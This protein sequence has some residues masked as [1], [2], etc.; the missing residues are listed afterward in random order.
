MRF[1]TGS[2]I[3]FFSALCFWGRAQ[4]PD[5]KLSKQEKDS[6][7]TKI[8]HLLEHRYV[9]PEKGKALNAMLLQKNENQ[10]FDSISDPTIFRE[11]IHNAIRDK[12]DDKHMRLFYF[13][14][15]ED[16]SEDTET[17]D[18]KQQYE[19]RKAMN[20]GIPELKVLDNNIG[21]LKVTKFT[22]PELFGPA[23]SASS[24]FLKNVEGLILDFRSRGGGNSDAVVLMLSYFLPAET[25]VFYWLD[26]NGN[27]L[28]RNWTFPYVAG[29]RFKDIPIVVL[30]SSKTFSGSEAFSYVMKHHNRATIIGE[31]TRGGAHTY[32][33]ISLSKRHDYL[34]TL[35]H[36]RVLVPK[37]NQNWEGVGVV[38]HIFAKP[39]A[40]MDLAKDWLIDKL[41][42]K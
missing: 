41:K 23:M 2:L 5:L 4:A 36:E 24:A 10:E 6:I 38:P 16:Q 14:P 31:Q 3:V 1:P 40:A 33:E 8:G 9:F 37:T 42:L 22:S 30:T 25:A 20:F 34:L 26:R 27:E 12:V 29:N 18:L 11:T 19:K 7:I 35:P 32:Q 21:Y 15:R 17:S 13:G 28:E 39:E